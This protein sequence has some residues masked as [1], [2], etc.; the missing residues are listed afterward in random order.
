MNEYEK[1]Y[2]ILADDGLNRYFIDSNYR[3]LF[4]TNDQKGARAFNHILKFK[5]LRDARSDLKNTNSLEWGMKYKVAHLVAVYEN[6][7]RDFV[8]Y[9]TIPIFYPKETYE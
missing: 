1:I 2:T 9:R 7:G 4:A 8:G 6:H 5:N 3:V